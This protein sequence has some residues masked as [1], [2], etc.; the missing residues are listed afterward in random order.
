M[1]MPERAASQGLLRLPKPIFK[2]GSFAEQQLAHSAGYLATNQHARSTVGN[3]TWNA[4][5]AQDWTSGFFS[6]C[7][8]LMYER[9]GTPQW[10]MRATQQ[11]LDLA[12]QEL[13]TGDHDIGFRILTSYGN[14]YRLTRNPAYKSVMLTAAQSFATR[15]DTTVGCT[16]SW[17][18]GPWQ[19]PVIIDNMM[20][21]E[22]LF[23]GARNGGDR[24]WHRMARSHALR[25]LQEHVR[26]DG[27][28]YHVVDYD[29]VTGGVLWKGTHQGYADGSTWA[30]GQAWAIYGFTM[31]YRYTREAVFLDAAERVADF[32]L[33]NLPADS[34]P[35]W[36]YDAP[37]IPGEPRDTSAAAIAAA[38][39]LELGGFSTSLV[40]RLRYKRAAVRIL[41]TLS[42]PTYLAEGT[43][44]EGIL[45]Q[46]VGHKPANS[47]V[48]VSLIYGDYY[49]LEALSR[50]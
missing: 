27:S 16:R 21:L 29:P 1:V 28:T 31:T 49:F 35:Y 45:L 24:A 18:F 23:W 22:L 36:D 20:N 2:A 48:D 43:S 6:G 33:A 15:Y 12:G 5:S 9:T 30:R 8:W 7:Q 46:G 4:V 17:D 47:E 26:V 50:L 42:S 13:N 41:K 14:A 40:D 3:G 34:I 19:Y 44:S 39:L 25:T 37:G 10:Q 38:G 11:T 32:M